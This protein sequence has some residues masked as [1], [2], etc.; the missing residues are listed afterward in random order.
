MMT[1]NRGLSTG[2]GGGLQIF[3]FVR[4]AAKSLQK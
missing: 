4:H 2:G 1:R 3:G